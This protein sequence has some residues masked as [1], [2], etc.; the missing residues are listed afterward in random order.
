MSKELP[1]GADGLVE[2]RLSWENHLG[3]GSEIAVKAFEIYQRRVA[4]GT[5]GTPERDWQLAEKMI[6]IKFTKELLKGVAS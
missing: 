6:R 2:K 4:K 1:L 5:S 3:N